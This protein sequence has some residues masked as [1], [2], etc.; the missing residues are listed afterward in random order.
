MTEIISEKVIKIGNI[1]YELTKKYC[2]QRDCTVL[3]IK[4]KKVPKEVFYINYNQLLLEKLQNRIE[5]L[6][7]TIVKQKEV[8][9]IKNNLYKNRK[10]LKKYN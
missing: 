4:S 1:Y 6:K 7:Y 8:L 2:L 10:K 9:E 5:K 3:P